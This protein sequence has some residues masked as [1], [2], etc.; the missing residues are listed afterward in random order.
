[1]Q[2]S[3]CTVAWV[4]MNWP[5]ALRMSRAWMKVPCYVPPTVDVTDVTRLLFYSFKRLEGGM[6]LKAAT[7]S[8]YVMA[9]GSI[10]SVIGDSPQQAVN[11]HT[12]GPTA[13]IH[14]QSCFW[15]SSTIARSDEVSRKT[16]DR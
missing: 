1:M 14:C 2:H 11:T 6:T 4:Y 16:V 13:L 12:K 15:P 7:T 8:S 10:Y 5:F 3:T 9:K